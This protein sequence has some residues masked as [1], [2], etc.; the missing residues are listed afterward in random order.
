[1]KKLT[2]VALAA[3][4]AAVFFADAAGTSPRK[5]TLSGVRKT[6]LD[7]AAGRKAGDAAAGSA[8]HLPRL[9]DRGEQHRP[10]DKPE[11]PLPV[12]RGLQLH[13]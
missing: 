11:K 6:P 7:R 13:S 12:R 8:R 5:H 3:L 1:M 2:V 10:A 9:A 4:L